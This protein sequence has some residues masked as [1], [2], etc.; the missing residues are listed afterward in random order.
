MDPARGFFFHQSTLRSWMDSE[1]EM[2]RAPVR[3]VALDG[4]GDALPRG[5]SASRVSGDSKSP[6]GQPP[7]GFKSRSRRHLIV[8]MICGLGLCEALR[9][10]ESYLVP[11]GLKNRT[12]LPSYLHSVFRPY[13]LLPVAGCESRRGKAQLGRGRLPPTPEREAQE[14]LWKG[15]RWVIRL[16][17]GRFRRLATRPQQAATRRSAGS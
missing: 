16:G 15:V 3:R 6:G 8:L 7:C 14:A 4:L 13:S 10:G 12:A 2:A 5:P 11:L 1:I 9:A 17:L